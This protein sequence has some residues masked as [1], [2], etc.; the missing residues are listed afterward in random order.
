MKATLVIGR[1]NNDNKN[2][3]SGGNNINKKNGSFCPHKN[4]FGGN[5]GSIL[6]N[7]KA[8]I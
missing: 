5:L 3:Q 1:G 4:F 6:K 8:H 2:N 7:F